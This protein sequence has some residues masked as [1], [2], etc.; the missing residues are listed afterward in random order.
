MIYSPYRWTATDEIASL[1][2]IA[3]SKPAGCVRYCRLILADQ[4]EWDASVDVA[5][6]K[7]EATRLTGMLESLKGMAAHA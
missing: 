6:V 4:R 3:L 2:S 5:A 1:R 7:L